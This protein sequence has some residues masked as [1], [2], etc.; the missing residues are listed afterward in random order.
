VVSKRGAGEYGLEVAPERYD[1]VLRAAM[2]VRAGTS[3]LTSV[4]TEWMHVAADLIQWC[5]RSVA[6]AAAP[7][8]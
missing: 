5:T 4:S 1:E 3:A 8:I 7:G 6:A 2:A